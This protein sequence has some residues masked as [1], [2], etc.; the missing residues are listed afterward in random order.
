MTPQLFIPFGE[1]FLLSL[2]LIVGFGP[3]NSFIL[4][5]GVKREFMFSVALLASLTDLCLIVLGVGGA[6][7]FF[8]D[9]P[10]VAQLVTV[11]G[12]VFLLVYGWKSVVSAFSQQGTV[13]ELSGRKLEYSAVILG[14]LGVSLL[15]PSAYLDTLF[16]I[17]G[18]AAHYSAALR[19][20]FALGATLASITWFFAL[21]FGAARL[22]TVLSSRRVSRLIALFSGAVMWFIAS[23]LIVSVLKV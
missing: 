8:A 21:A 5:Q 1:G 13:A 4:Q 2:G 18:G 16:I 15:N 17:G 11:A 22:S 6:G 3:Q 9:R 10:L 12:I 19:V 7:S 23:R 14:I 20:F